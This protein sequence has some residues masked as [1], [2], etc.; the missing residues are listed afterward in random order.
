ML[1]LPI[2]SRLGLLPSGPPASH[3][4][5]A[6]THC[7][8]HQ[9]QGTPGH[10]A[11]AF[12]FAF[13]RGDWPSSECRRMERG[14]WVRARSLRVTPVGGCY[15]GRCGGHCNGCCSGHFGGCCNGR[16]S[17]HWSCLSIQLDHSGLCALRNPGLYPSS[18]SRTAGRVGES[19]GQPW[20]ERHLDRR[21]E[22]ARPQVLDARAHLQPRAGRTAASLGERRNV[23]WIGLG[24]GCVRTG[25][26]DW[27]ARAA[28]AAAMSCQMEPGAAPMLQG[29]RPS[30]F[31]GRQGCRWGPPKQAWLRG[32]GEGQVG[33]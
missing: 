32:P 33:G 27:P 24:R 13:E 7:P 15:N 9:L 30:P 12:A 19:E 23:S 26:R 16:R 25:G 4:G 14:L 17:G 20:A 18:T 2:P 29:L 10:P 22:S 21:V 6:G 3:T 11:F 28:G 31:R 1:P 8:S 5:T